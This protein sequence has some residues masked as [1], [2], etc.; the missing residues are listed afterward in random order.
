MSLR[1]S[2][3][4]LSLSSLALAEEPARDQD[5][6][7]RINF[8]HALESHGLYQGEDFPRGCLDWS[9]T[10]KGDSVLYA[11][12]LLN[13]PRCKG[14]A[15][16]KDRWI[17]DREN[18]SV[19]LIA[20]P[21]GTQRLA[22]GDVAAGGREGNVIGEDETEALLGTSVDTRDE[23]V[24][25]AILAGGGGS[26]KKARPSRQQERDEDGYD[27][28]VAGGSSSPKKD[29]RTSENVMTVTGGVGFGTGGRAGWG[30]GNGGT[31]SGK[32]NAQAS[33]NGKGIATRAKI[34][35]PKPS[36]IELSGDAGARSPE[37]ILQVIRVHVGGFR[38]TYDKYLKEYPSLGGGKIVLKFTI[39]PSGDIIAIAIAASNTGNSNLDDEIKDKAR[40]MK[41]DQIEKGNAVVTYSMVLEPQ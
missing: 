18:V 32:M 28:I 25:D 26:F 37:S 23:N 20:G 16:V 34:D 6:V 12:K 7:D 30:T 8:L 9:G 17:M 22:I 19:W 35:P 15:P 2:L 24:I 31:G 29:S 36:D 27:A 3:A 4:L 1:L 11:A 5:I 10:P 39:A 38:H 33:R 14:I 40:R 13:Q 41:F 21:S